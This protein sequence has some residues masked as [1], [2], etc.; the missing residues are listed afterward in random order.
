MLRSK[1][2]RIMITYNV[3]CDEGLT[4]ELLRAVAVAAVNLE[5]ISL[6]RMWNGT[7]DH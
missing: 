1:E 3:V 2:G 4:R 7:K 6:L 5:G